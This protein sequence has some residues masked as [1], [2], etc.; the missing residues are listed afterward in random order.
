M[1]WNE[2]K[3][4]EKLIQALEISDNDNDFEVTKLAPLVCIPAYSNDDCELTY[5][6]SKLSPLVCILK[7]GV[8]ASLG[9]R[10]AISTK[11]LGGWMSS[12]QNSH[13]KFTFCISF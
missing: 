6:R 2:E 4:P 9:R 7:G 13:F 12:F 11:C 3:G 1:I 8:A 10:E 5:S